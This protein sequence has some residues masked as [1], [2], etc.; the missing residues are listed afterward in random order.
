MRD[1]LGALDGRLS[2]VTAA[3]EGTT[4]VG[5]VPLRTAGTAPGSGDARDATDDTA[6]SSETARA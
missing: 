3:G 2:M 4:V 1:R 6:Q 5:A